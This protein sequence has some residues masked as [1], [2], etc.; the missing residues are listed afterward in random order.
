M[1]T[2]Y[3]LT[4]DD[5]PVPGASFLEDVIELRLLT[6]TDSLGPVDYTAPQEHPDF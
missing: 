4:D 5:K 3:V 1:G 2:E 6:A